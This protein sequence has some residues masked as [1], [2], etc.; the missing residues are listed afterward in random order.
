MSAQTSRIHNIRDQIENGFARWGEICHDHPWW[1]I[2]TVVSALIFFSLWL[3]SMQIDTS[4]ESYLREDNPARETYHEFQ[5]EFGQDE[6]IVL[7][8]QSTND[9]LQDGFLR[10]LQALHT[11]LEAVPQVEKV[12]SILNARLTRGEG[13]TLIVEDLF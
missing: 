3:P 11:E 6:R 1:I 9:I 2:G 10:H 4:N 8:I 12:E 5:R 7:L 13:D